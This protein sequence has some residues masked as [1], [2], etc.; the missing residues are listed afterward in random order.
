[1]GKMV[2]LSAEEVERVLAIDDVIKAVEGAYEQKALGRGIAW[3]MV[4]EQF[5][6]DVA[7]MDIR[8]G[9]LM[10]SGLFG[11]KL[12]AWFSKNPERGLPDIYGTTLLCDDTTGEP[13]CLLNAS[14]VTGLR[15][16]AAGAL[17]VK[18]LARAD[19]KN[20][21]V[22]GAGHMSAFEV[23]RDARCLPEHHARRGV[24]AAELGGS[25]GSRGG[26][27]RDRRPRALRVR[28]AASGRHV[29][30]P[31]RCRWRGRR[32]P[33]R[34]HHHRHA[35]DH[36]H[37]PGRLGAAGHAHLERRRG[38]AGQAGALVRARGARPHLRGRPRAGREL[39]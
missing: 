11:L 14:A 23:A 3:P 37:H 24:G 10:A 7:D 34:C 35:G 28:R 13:L 6:P 1:M 22:A 26:D 5:E 21:L 32:A 33:C 9:E 8:S 29:R 30:D 31:R 15:T 4:Y 38:Y 17:G 25:R 27:P 20:L 36:A 16:G 12:T 19:A 2:V 39:G 18:W